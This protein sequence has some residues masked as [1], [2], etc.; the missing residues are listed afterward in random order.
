[1]KKEKKNLSH[2]VSITDI[3]NIVKIDKDTLLKL[4]KNSEKLST[5]EEWGVDNWINYGWEDIEDYMPDDIADK[6]LEFCESHNSDEVY[7]Y[8]KRLYS[9]IQV[10][11]LEYTILD[12]DSEKGYVEYK[13]I[14]KVNNK[15]YSFDYYQ[16]PYWNFKDQADEDL[17]EVFPK[18]ITTVIYV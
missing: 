9:Y 4:I 2:E 12:I 11:N 10:I 16:S 6:Y 3:G 7:D 17:T 15:Y 18:E 5:L 13:A 1:M 14:I 8:L